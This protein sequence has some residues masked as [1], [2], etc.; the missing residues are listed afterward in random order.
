MTVIGKN[1]RNL[2]PA[3]HNKVSRESCSVWGKIDPQASQCPKRSMRH[4]KKMR[5]VIGNAP[6]MTMKEV[7]V[8]GGKQNGVETNFEEQSMA[9]PGNLPSTGV[10]VCVDHCP[11]QEKPHTRRCEVRSFLPYIFELNRLDP[12]TS[13]L[14]PPIAS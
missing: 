9:T 8:Q 10:V 1:S 14:L 2:M 11:Q 3:V 6:P 13:S 5:V 12:L 4:S 7:M